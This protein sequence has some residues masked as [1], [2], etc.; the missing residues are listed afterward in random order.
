M[1]QQL[2]ALAAPPEDLG[3]IP[4]IPVVANGLCNVSFTGSHALFWLPGELELV[5][6]PGAYSG[7]V[8]GHNAHDQPDLEK[9][10]DI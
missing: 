7:S 5:L 10:Q 4:S 8:S 2:Q 3:V 1:I 9:Q 6:Q